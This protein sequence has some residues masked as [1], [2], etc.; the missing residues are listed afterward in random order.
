MLAKPSLNLLQRTGGDRGGRAQ[1]GWRTF[2]MT[3]LRWILGYVRLEIWCKIGLSAHWCLCI[4]L[5]TR[6]GACCYWIGLVCLG[7]CVCRCMCLGKGIPDEL[8]IQLLVAFLGLHILEWLKLESLCVTIGVVHILFN[9]KILFLDHPP[10]VTLYNISLT[11]P[12]VLYCYIRNWSYMPPQKRPSQKLMC[13][14]VTIT[15][16]F[17]VNMSGEQ[18]V[19]VEFH[20]FLC[21]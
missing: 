3:C 14:T 10:C 2:M 9:T 5:C 15:V 4:V 18:H 13:K 19:D 7:T 16:V 12:P 17:Q 11:H 20:S 6:S 8:A 21:V 1:P